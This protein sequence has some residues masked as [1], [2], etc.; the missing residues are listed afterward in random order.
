IPSGRCGGGRW[1]SGLR[2]RD[3][4]PAGG[5]RPAD[6]WKWAGNRLEYLHPSEFYGPQPTAIIP[7]ISGG[8]SLPPD[9]INGDM[10]RQQQGYGRGF[11]MQ[12]EKD[13][14]QIRAGVRKG[15]TLGSPITL[16]VENAD[17]RSWE[18]LMSPDPGEMPNQKMVTRPRP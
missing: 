10:A 14:A 7:G 9:R 6:N 16:V 3:G 15:V 5:A 1:I 2:P 17:Y 11:R 18:P 8:L 4:R 12:I 13:R